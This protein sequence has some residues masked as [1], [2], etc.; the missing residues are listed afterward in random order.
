MFPGGPVLSSPGHRPSVSASRTSSART[1]ACAPSPSSEPRA[2]GRRPRA[3]RGSR[4]AQDRGRRIRGS[5]GRLPR[6]GGGSAEPPSS[7][8][9]R[10]RPCRAGPCSATPSRP[11]SAFTCCAAPWSDGEPFRRSGRDRSVQATS[12]PRRRADDARDAP[13]RSPGLV[14]IALIAPLVGQT[15]VVVDSH[16]FPDRRLTRPPD[17]RQ[18]VLT[19]GLPP[20]GP[21]APRR[22]VPPT[23]ASP[24]AQS[25]VAGAP[26]R[27]RRAGDAPGAA[28]PPER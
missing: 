27:S 17:G 13:G 2:P 20:A 26:A 22:P 25:E 1:S 6:R 19:R 23:R 21:R 28:Q 4:A 9:R 7:C 10:S 8:W 14:G 3:R 15:P 16:A 5:G 12:R 11:P 24:R 18:R